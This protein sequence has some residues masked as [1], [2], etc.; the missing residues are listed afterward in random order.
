METPHLT[1]AR[2]MEDRSLPVALVRDD[3]RRDCPLHTHEFSEIVIVLAGGGFHLTERNE[4]AIA[5]GD[6]FLVQAGRLHGYRVPRRLEIANVLFDRAAL[7]IPLADL[8][9]MPG[10]HALFTLEPLYRRTRSFADRLRLGRAQLA[11]AAA[12]IAEF[13]REAAAREP[14]YV[15]ATVAIF[16]RLAV[17]LSRCYAEADAPAARPSTGVGRAL[18]FLEGQID[19]PLALAQV[20]RAAGMSTSGLLREFRRATGRSPIDYHQRLRLARACEL[21]RVGERSV[22][23]VAADVGFA[24]AGYFA[25]RFRAAMGVSPREY[26][27]R[28]AGL[29]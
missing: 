17:H 13:E 19:R 12:L 1:I 3:R 6:A 28:E 26:R 25:R 18:G 9:A 8:T 21:L 23:E 16:L 29:R 27:R 15:L 10:Y 5:R 2:C 4:Y 24:D 14:G 7:G 20:A 22:A 11:R